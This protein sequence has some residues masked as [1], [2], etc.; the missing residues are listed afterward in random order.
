MCAAPIYFTEARPSAQVILIEA[1]IRALEGPLTVRGFQYAN[2]S[3]ASLARRQEAAERVHEAEYCVLRMTLPCPWCGRP[4]RDGEA[5]TQLGGRSLHVE[6]CLREFDAF[7]RGSTA[8]TSN[9]EYT[10][11]Q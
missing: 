1:A 11:I 5:T 4:V 2:E 7:T 10:S 3:D 8:D 9:L 6:P